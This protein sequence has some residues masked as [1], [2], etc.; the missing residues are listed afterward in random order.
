MLYGFNNSRARAALCER[1]VPHGRIHPR[2]DGA[3]G[4]GDP[5]AFGRCIAVH[6]PS[7][8]TPIANQ[9]ASGAAP[10]L[11]PAPARS[12]DSLREG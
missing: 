6:G 10:V 8:P 1:E 5:Y 7:W 2:S 4:P 12:H 3:Y 9:F 11:R